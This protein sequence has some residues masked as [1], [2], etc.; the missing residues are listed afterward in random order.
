MHDGGN[1]EAGPDGQ[2]SAHQPDSRSPFPAFPNP[3]RHHPHAGWRRRHCA[4]NVQLQPVLASRL[5]TYNKRRVTKGTGLVCQAMATSPIFIVIG[6]KFAVVSMS[7]VSND[8][9]WMWRK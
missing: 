8:P 3:A 1:G 9:A 7:L 6:L 4:K 5:L 2:G